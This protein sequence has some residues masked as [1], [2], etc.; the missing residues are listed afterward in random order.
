MRNI[1]VL[2]KGTLKPGGTSK[3]EDGGSV[4]L[5][6]SVFD[7]ISDSITCVLGQMEIGF[8][9]VEQYTKTGSMNILAS[10]NIETFNDKLLSFAHFDDMNQLVFVF[11]QGD[12]YSVTYDSESGNP[13]AAVVEVVGSID[14]G[15]NAAQ[16]SYDEE[17]LTLV[18]ADDNV[19]VLSRFFES[20]ADTH[21]ETA[22]LKKSKHVTVGWGKK[23][24]QFRGKGAREAERQA[25]ASL[26]ASGL[27]GDQLRDPT[28]PYI[29]D[30]GNIT[31]LDNRNVTISWKSDCEFFCVSKI[32]SVQDPDDETNIIER[33]VLRIYSR[34]GKLDSASE[35][36]TGMEY[37]L[38]WKPHAPLIASVQRNSR[39]E[40]TPSLDI[41]FF[42]RNGLRHGEFNTRLP[43][44]EPIKQL[45]WSSNS[46]ILTVVLDHKIQI[47][48][49]NNYHWYLK[50]EIQSN[51]IAFVKW[52]PEKDFTL[53]FGGG[54]NINIVDF[55][56]KMAQ[57]PT[58][59][60]FDKGN[61][62]VIDGNTVKITPLS[63]SNIPPPMSY[64]DISCS[65]NIQDV[66]CSI[67][68]E[69]IAAL[70]TNSLVIAS[71]PYLSDIRRKSE[72]KQIIEWDKTNFATE[73]D[74]LRQVAFI[75]DE[76][77]AILLD[78]QNMSRIALIDAH[79]ILQPRLIKV[80]DVFEKVVLLRADFD[81][82]HLVFQTRTAK[83][84]QMDP[85]GEFQ[86][87]AVFPQLVRDFRVKKIVCS[88]H[89]SNSHWASG[90]E[91][92][93]A[94]GLTNNGK[95][96]AQD[97]LLS[98]A[99]TSIEITDTLLLFTTA[100]HNLQFVHLNS[101]EFK[102]LPLV[103]ANV[104]DERIRSVERG[105]II[106][107]V[108]TSKSAVVLQADRGNL[109]TIY[110]RLM[111]LH[112]VRKN[113]LAKDYKNAFIL[114]RAH[115]I[116]LDILYDYAPA[117]FLENLE[118]FIN[119]V[120]KV[121][122]LNLFISCL[123][124]D[125]VVETKYRETLNFDIANPYD[126][127]PPP[128]TEMQ[129]YMKKK[130]FDP[131]NSKVNKICEAFLNILLNNDVLKTKY[132]SS[133]LTAY[134][135]QKPQNLKGALRLI[136]TLND[137]R[138]KD[139][140]VTYLCFLQDVNLLYKEALA[141][142]DV[143]LALRVAQES[144]M[145]PREYLPFLQTLFD[146]HVMYRKFSIDDYLGNYELALESLVEYE[147]N[148][149]DV[150]V[151]K[152]L[153]YVEKHVLY[154]HALKLYRYKRIQ[155]DA[156]YVK[157]ASYLL[158]KQEYHEAGVIYEMLKD[159]RKAKDAYVMGKSWVEAMAITAK[160]FK[161]DIETIA[162]GLI[163]SLTFDHMYIDA[164]DIELQ[165]MK[166]IDN[167]MELYCKA[168]R[169]D[170]ACLVATSSGKDELIEKIVDFRLGEGFGVIAELV[171]DCKLQMNSQL[172]RLRELRTR[173]EED[174]Y[175]FYG[176]QNE[177]ADDV[178]IAPS[179]TST[180]D[181]F[182]TKYTGKT[183]ITAKTGASRRTAKNKRREERK[184]AR[185]KKGTIYEE[186]YLVQS[187]GRL[188]ERLHNTMADAVRLIDGLCR[189]N[190]REQAHQIQKNYSEVLDNL[191]TNVEEIYNISER[192]RERVDENG[193]MY[194]IP[195][196]PVPIIKTFP[197][198]KF[199]EY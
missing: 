178:S 98:S 73:H 194:L 146:Q 58:R 129:E 29:V 164:A 155:Q 8:I 145:D 76:T 71:L 114:C 175:A 89:D 147:D 94:F 49:M 108:M 152:I 170:K 110:P 165:F 143:K 95:L 127:V 46:E 100:Q 38:S 9:T 39:L 19:V 47:W 44:D 182:F 28:M 74:T 125:N 5:L 17:I 79:D 99:V 56:Y 185:G 41:I 186:E 97:V 10:F 137:D 112:E 115:R 199:I 75:D 153:E 2:N 107:S 54:N 187:T 7:T 180:K 184:R 144:Q 83:I 26:K 69:I 177:Q 151:D 135:S 173:K 59:E 40:G 77:V 118:L 103:E 12:I 48:T 51:D 169:Y 37:Q 122:F 57:G 43:F 25:L 50:Q 23:E 179:E 113:I 150:V 86:Q 190:M 63:I 27:V 90:I 64:R 157:Y 18:T 67:S 101:T 30:A 149:N 45:S 163:T 92:V 189:R 158:W 55:A 119:Q 91:S 70:T 6:D 31:E 196:I 34:D 13:S 24:T 4:I 88:T 198:R 1:V 33:R 140:S 61:S 148:D 105:S 72:D 183:G 142:Y 131:S 68:N 154:Q 195:E 134:S 197:N 15:L 42:E 130:M 161:E 174:P 78:S 60:P 93:V 32:D 21:M 14:R 52:H 168:Y 82:Q 65:D 20:I 96:Y 193:E 138:Q 80:V 111:V 172:K 181:S 117:L 136:S 156:I 85:N 62:M 81:Y 124:E 104:V 3:I 162:E 139:T 141:I 133:I 132:L 192:D 109:E 159:Y 102:T 191:R 123:S 116:N 11:Q 160:Y 106:V 66:C 166:N 176:Q 188:I 120:E 171:A 128:L 16:W 167:A 84:M 126:T 22:D 36:V 121:E 35:P 53:M 87:V